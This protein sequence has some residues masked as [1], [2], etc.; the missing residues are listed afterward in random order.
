M[1]LIDLAVL[2]VAVWLGARGFVKGLLKEAMEAASAL[3][4]VVVASRN[5][6]A[7]GDTVAIWTGLPVDVT[8]PVMYAVVAVS[9]TATGFF[10]TNLLH[11][12]LPRRARARALDDFGGLAFGMLKGLFFAALF[13]IAAAQIPSAALTRVLAGSAFS[14]TVFALAPVLYSR[15]GS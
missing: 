3:I 11:A 7:L 2:V 1:N 10:I 6:R 12:L 9:L 5:Y 13:V 15:I 8:R 14:R 4:G